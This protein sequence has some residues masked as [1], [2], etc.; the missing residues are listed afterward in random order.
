V[1]AHPDPDGRAGRPFVPGQRLL[2]LQRAQDGLLRTRE[3]HEERVTL[4]VYL[5][6][7]LPRDGLADQAPVLRQ[8]LCVAFPQGLY[9]PGR[10]LDIA[11][12]EGDR[13]ARKFR[14]AVTSRQADGRPVFARA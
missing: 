7:S 10:T 1:N 6:A 2:Y 8:Y 12:E 9:Q 3:R 13:P 5:V 4:G 14:H 11:E